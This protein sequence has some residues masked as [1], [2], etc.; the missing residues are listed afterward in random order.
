MPT[1]Q[2]K[3]HKTIFEEKCKD[4]NMEVPTLDKHPQEQNGPW[5][6]WSF[7]DTVRQESRNETPLEYYMGDDDEEK[8]PRVDELFNSQTLT[9]NASPTTG[10]SLEI[11]KEK[12]LSLFKPWRGRLLLN[13]WESQS[14][15]R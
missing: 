1:R 10:P 7:A 5:K 11:S 12:Y 13:Y 9:E 15:I 4:A 14:H 3:K 8:Y 2:S 6:G